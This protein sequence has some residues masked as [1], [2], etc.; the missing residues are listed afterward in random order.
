MCSFETAGIIKI[1]KDDSVIKQNN[2]LN[3]NLF[4]KI[5]GISNRGKKDI[6]EARP[7]PHINPN[8]IVYLK[9]VFELR[10]FSE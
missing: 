2:I 1:K 9:M 4:I 3:E 10:V 8:T 5:K 6:L 7:N